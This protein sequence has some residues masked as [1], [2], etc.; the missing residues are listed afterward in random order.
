M[1]KHLS[2]EEKLNAENELKENMA[3]IKE[4][5]NE[6]KKIN[7]RNGRLRNYLAFKNRSKHQGMF[8]IDGICYKM[9]G[10]KSCELTVEERR[11]YDN[12]TKKLRNQKKA[13]EMMKSE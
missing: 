4:L 13:K 5:R 10:K 6:I 2:I 12:Y 1:G 9:F 8:G 7:Y 3:K 11:K